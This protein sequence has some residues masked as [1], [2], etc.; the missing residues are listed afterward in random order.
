MITSYEI[1]HVAVVPPDALEASLI[2]KV[3]AIINKDVYGTRL[4][5]TGKIPR[6]IAHYQT[7]QAAEL[8]AQSLRALGLVPMVCRDSELRKPLHN[9]I[10]HVLQ[11]H[12]KEVMFRGKTGESRNIESADVF[13]FWDAIY[14]AS[15]W[16]GPS[17]RLSYLLHLKVNLGLASSF[18]R[19]N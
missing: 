5:L 2:T 12:D 9:F 19:T 17:Q 1:V 10:A 18:P 3:A 6:I 4:L 16:V 7:F 14:Y 13:L 8:I 15:D 11:F